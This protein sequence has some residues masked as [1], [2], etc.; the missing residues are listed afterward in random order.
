MI[1]DSPVDEVVDSLKVPGVELVEVAFA[2][3][4]DTFDEFQIGK[5]NCLASDRWRLTSVPSGWMD[6]FGLRDVPL[7]R[8][9][10]ELET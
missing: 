4:P 1:A 5:R 7:S 2:R 6:W 10:V 9:P 3:A 8:L